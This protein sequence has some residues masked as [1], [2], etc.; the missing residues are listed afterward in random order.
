MILRQIRINLA[1]LLDNQTMVKYY[2]PW[3]LLRD[4]DHA[5]VF[6]CS[7]QGIGNLKFSFN[8]NAPMLDTWG[9][10]TLE[11]AAI[12][13]PKANHSSQTSIAKLA[14]KKSSRSINDIDALSENSSF[15]SESTNISMMSDFTD[16]DGVQVLR[17]K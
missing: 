10:N 11:L 16:A 15:V 9:Q 17:K 2:E 8:T 1:L 13:A 5:E 7:L 12:I 6:K 14:H 4:P 3:A